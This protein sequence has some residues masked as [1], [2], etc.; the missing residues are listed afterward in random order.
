MDK[1]YYKKKGASYKERLRCPL[2]G[3]LSDIGFFSQNHQFGIYRFCFA[4]YKKISCRLVK[5]TPEF[6]KFLRESLI[7]R[8]LELLKTFAGCKYYSQHEMDEL[9]DHYNKLLAKQHFI[10]PTKPSMMIPQKPSI[11]PEM[12]SIIIPQKISVSVDAVVKPI[13][14]PYKVV[15]E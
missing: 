6:M 12:P 11:I 1:R 8:F 15:V 14:K 3:K 5:K 9:V 4:G 13:V 2:C 7:D 10:P